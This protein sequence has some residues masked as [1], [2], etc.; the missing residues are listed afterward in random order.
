[1]VIVGDLVDQLRKD[2]EIQSLSPCSPIRD[3]YHTD[4]E[5]I[6]HDEHD[7]GGL[8]TIRK[9]VRPC[10]CQPY[11]EAAGKSPHERSSSKEK[12]KGDNRDREQQ[13]I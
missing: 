4:E 13:L 2:A 5:G 12:E 3:L 6:E 10:R 8:E 7:Q 9:P 1:L 11:K